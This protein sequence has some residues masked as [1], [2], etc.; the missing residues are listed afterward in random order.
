MSYQFAKAVDSRIDLRPPT[1]VIYESV[2]SVQY[3]SFVPPT[4]SLNPVITVNTPSASQG[5]SREIIFNATVSITLTG[6]NMQNFLTSQCVSLR[7]F[8]IHQC[9]TNVS[10]QLG[11]GNVNMQPFNYTSALLSINN[12]TDVQHR[13]QSGTGS[14]SDNCTS[15]NDIVGYV[16][17]PF[18]NQWD[19]ASSQFINSARTNQITSITATPTTLTVVF[20]V[21]EPLMVS[22][23][24]YSN[25][26]SRSIFGLDT[27]IFSFSFAYLQ[28]MLSYAIPVGST[29]SNVSGVFNS[30]SLLCQ[31]IA[32]AENSV[33]LIMNPQVYNWTNI[34]SNDTTYQNTVVSGNTFSLSTN[35]VQ[36]AIIPTYF[37]IYAIPNVNDLTGTTSLP[38]FFFPIQSANIQFAMRSGILGNATPYQLYEI[39]KKNGAICNF[40]QFAGSSV[41]SSLGKAGNFAGSPL[42]LSVAKDLSLPSDVSSGMSYQTTFQGQFT[43][44]NQTASSYSNITVRVIALTD[45][46]IEIVPNGSVNTVMGNIT[47]QDL[48]N[49]KELPLLSEVELKAETGVNG[50]SGG[51]VWSKLKDVFTANNIKSVAKIATPLLAMSGHPELAGL[52]GAV[53]GMGVASR[54]QL[55]NA[56]RKSAY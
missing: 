45:G 29:V 9:L 20:T 6:T 40:P 32:P 51:S 24:D 11:S 1:Y 31:F 37:L 15:Y 7:Q 46:Y 5:L 54:G 2:P 38:D 19:T 4:A 17:S 50:Y 33:S 13:A 56:I 12:P 28:R 23:F 22:P 36:Y 30:Q 8:P 49:A 25:Y 41:Y 47:K 52:A 16:G 27:L 42:V 18:S 10:V 55:R 21:N 35:S 53:A 44:L 34:Q 14:T 39:S 43:F 48:M 26:G 3:T